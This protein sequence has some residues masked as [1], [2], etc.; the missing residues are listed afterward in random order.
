MSN[1]SG[2]DARPS[3]ADASELDDESL[4]AALTL[5]PGVYS[6]NRMFHLYERNARALELRARANRL[7]G[8]A[9]MWLERTDAALSL[10]GQGQ[11]LELVL[12]VPSM[13]YRRTLR[14]TE[15]ERG[16]LALLVEKAVGPMPT[17]SVALAASLDDKS[18]VESALARLTAA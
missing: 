18:R 3:E 7:R 2:A 9:R 12:D 10:Q 16:L 8:V 6:R 15:F 14:I 13:A 11:G 17:R 4:L 1:R 5:A